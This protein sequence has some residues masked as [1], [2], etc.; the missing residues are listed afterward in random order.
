MV[1]SISFRQRF[2][3]SVL[4]FGMG[5]SLLRFAFYKECVHCGEDVVE[6]GDSVASTDATNDADAITLLTRPQPLGSHPL[7]TP[8]MSAIDP[9]LS[10]CTHC[11]RIARGISGVVSR[12]DSCRESPIGKSRRRKLYVDYT[13]S[14]YYYR[15]SL[16]SLLLRSKL[17]YYFH[18]GG[19]FDSLV[20]LRHMDIGDVDI[21]CHI[22]THITRRL[23]RF[24][25]P[26]TV[27]A[28][29]LSHHTG[30]P[31]GNVLRRNRRTKYQTQLVRT[32]RTSNVEGAFRIEGDVDGQTILLVD[33][34]LTTG[35]TA[36]ECA[37]ALKAH[38]AACV[39]LYTLAC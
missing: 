21:I 39:K 6:L 28:S 9:V 24:R 29:A 2:F 13:E 7:C 36:N 20:H 30:V 1:K 34:I 17:Q 33:D 19:V 16:R 8:C 26:N 11:G 38:G 27:V 15:G 25:H 5:S 18:V 10:Y 37:K 31:I 22:P 4:G 14:S 3:A 12:C 32:T 23:T 35:A